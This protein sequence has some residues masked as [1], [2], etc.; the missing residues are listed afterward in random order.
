MEIYTCAMTY[1]DG[2]LYPRRGSG[3]LCAVDVGEEHGVD[4][5]GLSQPG[6]AND[7]QV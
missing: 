3:V 6:L 1:L 2:F 5:G 7:L 4:Q